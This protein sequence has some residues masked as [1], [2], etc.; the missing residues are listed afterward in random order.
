MYSGL[1]VGDKPVRKTVESAIN[2]FISDS[3]QVFGSGYCQS[4]ISGI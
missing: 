3:Q 4:G 2:K 1:S